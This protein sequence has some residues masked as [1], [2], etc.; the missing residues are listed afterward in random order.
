MSSVSS[1]RLGICIY[2]FQLKL[3]RKRIQS[4]PENELPKFDIIVFTID[5]KGTTWF[6]NEKS[7][8]SD[9]YNKGWLEDFRKEINLI[10]F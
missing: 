9:R 7:W 6:H 1:K 2:H 3:F 5:F 4:T 10:Y 8:K